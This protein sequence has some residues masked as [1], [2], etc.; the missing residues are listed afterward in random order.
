MLNN[1]MNQNGSSSTF[2]FP[3]PISHAS[4]CCLHIYREA[5]NYVEDR[6]F[7]RAT[8]FGNDSV[9]MQKIIDSQPANQKKNKAMNHFLAP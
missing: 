4:F 6:S 2:I 5:L 3:K 7:G 1:K 9:F 8:H